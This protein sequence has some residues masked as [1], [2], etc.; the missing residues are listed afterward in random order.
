MRFKMIINMNRGVQ[1]CNEPE[2]VVLSGLCLSKFLK[3]SLVLVS[4]AG[5]PGLLGVVLLHRA[6]SQLMPGHASDLGLVRQ[7]VLLLEL[8]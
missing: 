5:V 1:G 6:F 2:A 7:E 3:L 4:D 8:E